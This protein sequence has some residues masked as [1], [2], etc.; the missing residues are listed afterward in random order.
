MSD[1]TRKIRQFRNAFIEAAVPELRRELQGRET[2]E[3][4]FK[5]ELEYQLRA[6]DVLDE[7]EQ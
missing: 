3:E 2:S 5:Q 7:E 6:R 1:P 4:R